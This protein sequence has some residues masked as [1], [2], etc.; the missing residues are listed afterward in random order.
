MSD[1]FK[2]YI[3]QS[4]EK[5]TSPIWLYTKDYIYGMFPVNN[6]SN[7]WME[8]TYDFDSD[9]PII[10][11]ERDA[12]LSYQFLFEELEKGIPYY[13]E[14][15]NVNNLKQFA[16]TVESKSGSEKLKTIISELINNT[17]KYSKNLP[18]IK[19]KEDAHLLKEKV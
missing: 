14:D 9:D 13:I 16:T 19:S 8:I 3:D 10:K 17:D 15:F 7:R 18:I 4:Y 1:E 12:D 5:G 11:K 2:N 6:D